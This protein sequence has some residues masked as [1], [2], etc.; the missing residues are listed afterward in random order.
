MLSS[1]EVSNIHG[2]HLQPVES[3]SLYIIIFQS[4]SQTCIS[5]TVSESDLVNTFFLLLLASSFS[6]VSLLFSL[7]SLPLLPANHAILSFFLMD[8]TLVGVFLA[9]QSLHL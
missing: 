7:V 6:L 1:S 4:A 9:L 3:L 2:G 8:F 5:F